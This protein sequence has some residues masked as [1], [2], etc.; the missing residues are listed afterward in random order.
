MDPIHYAK[1][2]DYRPPPKLY[3]R[4]QWLGVM[5][6]SLGMAPSDAVTLEIVGRRSGKKRRT[7]VVRIE[8]DGAGYVVALAGE[9]QWVRNVRA[10]DGAAVIKRRGS[11][12]VRLVELPVAE[13]PSVI[14]AYMNRGGKFRAKEAEFYFGLDA[15]STAEDILA[16]A[17]HYPVFRVDRP[18]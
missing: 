17:S 7:P 1:R 5:L 16:I 8:H 14:A 12:Q 10:A 6:T 2:T 4:M 18:G 15:D 13:R 9:S 11:E 3:S